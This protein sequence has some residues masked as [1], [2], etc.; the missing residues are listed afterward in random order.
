M[1]PPELAGGG[2]FTFEDAPVAIYLGALLGEKSAPGLEDRTVMRVAVQQAAYGEPLDDLIADGRGVDD[3]VARLSLQTKRELTISAATTNTD[4]REIVTRAWAT[5]QKPGFRENIDRVGAVTG[6]ISEASRRAFTTICEWARASTTLDAFLGHFQPGAADAD[7]RN[8][9]QAVLEILGDGDGTTSEVQAYRLLRHFVLINIDVLH[10]GATHDAHAIERLRP[11]LHEPERAGDLWQRLLRIARD[12]AGRA[13]EFSRLSLLP[14]LHGTFRLVGARSLRSDLERISEETQNALDSIICQ[15]DGVEISRLSLVDAVKHALGLR[16]FV[17]IIGLPGTGKS[18]VLHACVQDATQNGTVLFLKSDRLTG[19]NWAAH[20]RSLGLTAPTIEALLCEISTIGS[21][22]LFI[23]GIDRVELGQRGVIADVLNA[24]HRSA[25]LSHWKIVATCRDNG[26]EPLRTWLPP[27]V[28]NGGGVSAVEVKPFDDSKSEQLAEAKPVLRPLL[29]S[30]ERVREIARRP[31][32]AAVLARSLQGGATGQP[33]PQS[34]IELLNVWWARGGYDSDEQRLYQRQRTLIQLAKAGAMDLGRRIRLEGIDVGAVVELR[35]DSIIKDVRAGHTVQFVHDIFFEWVFLHLL[36][37][38]D[39]AWL[40]EIRA[41]GEPPLLGRVVEL[42]SQATL[43]QVGD[44]ERKLAALEASGMRP[45]WT[46][47]WLIAPFGAPTFWDHAARFTEAVFRNKAQ[48]LSKLAV[49][50][51]AEKTRANPYVLDRTFGSGNL[52]RRDIV[53]LADALAWPS[54]PA[55]WGRFCAW[56]IG[57]VGE[58][59]TETIPDLLAAFEVWQ[60][61]LADHPN[62]VSRQIFATAL[63]WLQDIEA[64]QHPERFSYNP[65]RWSKLARGGIEELEQRLRALILRAA[66]VEQERVRAYLLRVRDWKRLRGHVLQQI[67]MF[68]PTLVAHHSAEIVSIAQF[69]IKGDLPADEEARER[70]G[71][72]FSS[73]ISYHDWHHLAIHDNVFYQLA[74]AG[75][76]SVSFPR[77]AAG[78]A[79]TRPRH[80]I[81]SGSAALHAGPRAARDTNL[82]CAG[83]SLGFAGILG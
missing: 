50:F 69:E 40:E 65:G 78:S 54:E 70:R 34:E 60:N 21:S 68:T 36:I 59:P 12:A 72:I 37:D 82:A 31:F 66:R 63:A 58:F 4:F 28:F 62:E 83:I 2:G 26:I 23:D 15:I 56:A 27:A 13:A 11:H 14:H 67:I 19:P 17:N 80:Q 25:L 35:R 8:A 41:V 5:V 57:N 30:D 39:A 81:G 73:G 42:L 22:I 52:A 10:E 46:R 16:R 71:S 29:F 48:R 53:R 32:F 77:Q 76:V 49:W 20:A 24:I 43:T 1:Q 74:V 7:K 79:R 64:R 3:S 18:A 45:Q 6:T 75:A 61:M 9:L 51:Q 55:S 47:A 38:R 44:W 33:A